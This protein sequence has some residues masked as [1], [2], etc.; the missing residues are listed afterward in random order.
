MNNPKVLFLDEPTT[1]VDPVARRS[2]F[3][4]LNKMKDNSSILLTTHKMDEAESLCDKI[5][6]MVKGKFVCYGS[7]EQLKQKYGQGYKIIVKSY[8]MINH[9]LVND[10]VLERLP[11]CKNE[12]LIDERS[13]MDENADLIYKIE[14]YKRGQNDP[15][16]KLSNIF[17]VMNELKDQKIISDYKITRSSLE[18]VLN[19]F[20]TEEPIIQS[21]AAPNIQM[22]YFYEN[23]AQHQDL[24][25]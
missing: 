8:P 23:V 3:K 16:M 24:V 2:L 13:Q 1:G 9:Q 20:Q 6:I 22:G 12:M 19:H 17:T 18:Q 14:G 11:Y 10:Y 7:P 25:Q 5:A 15:K 21:I 4:L